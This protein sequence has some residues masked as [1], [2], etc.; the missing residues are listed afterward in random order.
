MQPL[1]TQRQASTLLCLSE[2]T[3]ERLRV[4]GTGPRFVRAGRS[5]RY[6]QS[7]LEAWIVE[8]VVGSTSEADQT[9]VV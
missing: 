1:L 6:R 8:R 2:R 4:A 9:S 3:L 7:D 5:V